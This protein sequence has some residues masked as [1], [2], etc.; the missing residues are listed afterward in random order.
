MVYGGI[1]NLATG[2]EYNW[3]DATVVEVQTD[4]GKLTS[5]EYNVGWIFAGDQDFE[6]SN[7]VAD[8]HFFEGE[9]AIVDFL[10]FFPVGT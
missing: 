2:E 1:I 6:E 7:I 5:T 3:D 10:H 9:T 8:Q 4:I